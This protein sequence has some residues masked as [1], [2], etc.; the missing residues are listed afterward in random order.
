MRIVIFD[1]NY[2]NKE[3]TKL[4]ARFCEKHGHTVD[5]QI[6]TSGCTPEYETEEEYQTEEELWRKFCSTWDD[7][8][9][10]HE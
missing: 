5:F 4:Y 8:K 10:T 3:E 9:Q 7:E 1:G 6:N 2:T